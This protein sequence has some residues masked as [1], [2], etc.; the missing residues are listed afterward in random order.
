MQGV[1][2]VIL[3]QNPAL[4]QRNAGQVEAHFV[5][6][7]V[8]TGVHF[9]YHADDAGGAGADG[10]KT[11][12]LQ[13][14]LVDPLRVNQLA[15]FNNAVLGQETVLENGDF[16]AGNGVIGNRANIERLA[17]NGNG[18]AQRI[19][20]LALDADYSR[21]VVAGRL[22][23][24]QQGARVGRVLTG[25]G[26]RHRILVGYAAKQVNGFNAAVNAPRQV[27]VIDEGLN[28]PLGQNAMLAP[29]SLENLGGSRPGSGVGMPVAHKRQQGFLRL[30]KLLRVGAAQ[31]LVNFDAAHLAQVK[32]PA[33]KDVVQHESA[34][35]VHL[36]RRFAGAQPLV[37][38]ALGQANAKRLLPVE[39]TVG[40]DAAPE[41]PQFFFPGVVIPVFGRR[42]AGNKRPAVV[43]IHIR[44]EGAHLLRAD[45]AQG[46]KE[47]GHVH[48]TAAVNA[49]GDRFRQVAA[50]GIVM[51]P[52][53][54]LNARAPAGRDAALVVPV[55]QLAA[56]RTGRVL[57]RLP[58]IIDAGRP[59][60]LAHQHPFRAIDQES[61]RIGH[62]RH[63]AKK[64]AL[65]ALYGL[66]GKRIPAPRRLD[67]PRFQILDPSVHVQRL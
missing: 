25:D 22:H 47:G 56:F 12:G 64:D 52:S 15:G 65:A 10:S 34:G 44:K 29:G 38:V 57:R 32:A 5:P 30:G 9:R 19:S 27:A 4:R 53:G 45:N 42:Y 28:I 7:A 48:P 63:I 26:E 41:R 21:R 61:P 46:V 20:A 3:V 55:L 62:H 13:R 43:G 24:G 8:G 23:Q 18:L 51:R 40:V 17:G 37:K 49:D 1:N 16:A 11:P 31:P 14:P 66:P 67:F 35:G 6:I 33:V 59:L 58:F 39:F 2:N 50:A 36:H 60:Q 54:E